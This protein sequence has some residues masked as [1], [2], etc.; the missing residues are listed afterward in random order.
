MK[1]RFVWVGKTKRGPFRELAED[2]LARVGRFARVEVVELR[3]RDDADARKIIEKE[4]E[5]ILS[6]TAGD[7]F[8][9]VLDEKGSE[10][11]SHDFARFIEKHRL[12]S[13]RQMTFVIGGHAG[14]SDEV[15][16]RADFTL[17]LSRMTLTHDFARAVLAEQVYRAFTIIHDL[18]Y[19]K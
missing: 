5:D 9:V 8:V 14:L 13:T 15:K 4:G 18:P 1:L 19:Q 17:A 12:A 3:D 6:R 2:Y 16:R 11:S 7:P 10:L